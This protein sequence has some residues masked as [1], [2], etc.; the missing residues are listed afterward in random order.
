M[1]EY[2]VRVYYDLDF[3]FTVEADNEHEAW[4]EASDLADLELRK[5][6]NEFNGNI[7][8]DFTD[9]LEAIEDGTADEEYLAEIYSLDESLDDE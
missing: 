1:P 2:V 9:T 7:S 5:I 3:T 8:H 4:D 6:P